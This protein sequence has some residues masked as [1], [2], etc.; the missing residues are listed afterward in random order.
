M[1]HRYR[2]AC[3][4]ALIIRA[5]KELGLG[6]PRVLP[7][8][9]DDPREQRHGLAVKR[10]FD[11]LV[12]QQRCL[13]SYEAERSGQRDREAASGIR[14]TFEEA[15]TASI[16]EL[17]KHRLCRT[18]ADFDAFDEATEAA[19]AARGTAHFL[20]V[21]MPRGGGGTES[22]VLGVPELELRAP[23]YTVDDEPRT[24]TQVAPH[25]AASFVAQV[26]VA[27]RVAPPCDPEVNRALLQEIN[28]LFDRDKERAA[29]EKAQD[30]NDVASGAVEVSA[31]ANAAGVDT[32]AV[33]RRGGGSAAGGIKCPPTAVA[34]RLEAIRDGWQILALLLG[35]MTWPKRFVD[36]FGRFAGVL[37]LDL[38][39][40][41][42][43]DFRYTFYLTGIPT[44]IASVGLAIL[45]ATDD[46]KDVKQLEAFLTNFRDRQV[47]LL[48]KG[49]PTSKARG[50]GA[51][52]AFVATVVLTTFYLPVTTYAITAVTCHPSIICAFD[53]YNEPAHNALVVFGVL[54]L[55]FVSALAPLALFV[56]TLRKVRELHAFVGT[57]EDPVTE[58]EGAVGALYPHRLQPVRT[59]VRRLH[60]ALR[61]LQLPHDGRQG[62]ARRG[63]AGNGAEQHG[64]AAADRPHRRTVRTHLCVRNTLHDGAA[65]HADARV[66]V[67]RRAR[68]EPQHP[69][70]GEARRPRARV[71]RGA[72]HCWYRHCRC[73]GHRVCMAAV[74]PIRRCAAQFIRCCL[75]RHVVISM[76]PLRS[77]F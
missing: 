56:F 38:G 39:L 29:S 63:G 30:V 47:R 44:L 50:A 15:L 37:V 62:R 11:S 17:E 1:L 58:E 46:A 18:D 10:I 74:D 77:S 5:R 20:G 70:P 52:L 59:R 49:K 28:D 60:P 71:R 32:D 3:H 22:T 48:A 65:E 12:V 72:R 9:F 19:L 4:G 66:A 36:T 34:A 7:R 68:A 27:S 54:I 40:V 57:V 31:T 14:R 23:S 21:A 55:I 53:C 2:H 13:L 69:P 24:V 64:A 16:L 41:A 51:N 45:L 35:S 8:I 61:L 76:L 33:V 6:A 73:A 75:T 43:L 42:T 26:T 25:E 67:L